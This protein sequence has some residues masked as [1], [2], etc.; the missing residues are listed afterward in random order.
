MKPGDIIIIPTDT[1]FGLAAVLYDDVA[2]ERIYHLKGREQSKQIPVLVASA[3]DVDAFAR[4]DERFSR[5]AGAFW[6]G[7]LSIVLP[8]TEAHMEKT[9]EQTVAVRM[10]ADPVALGLLRSVGPLRATSL[11][12]SG[13]PPVVSYEDALERFADKVDHVY[14]GPDTLMSETA[15]TVIAFDH[16]EVKILRQ[17]M[18]TKDM[19]KAVLSD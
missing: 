17:G 15:S 5:L 12:K 9:G 11:N 4:T 18:I 10:P 14:G 1:V 8:T 2:L 7:P 16:D 19:I 3:N 6:P 13:E